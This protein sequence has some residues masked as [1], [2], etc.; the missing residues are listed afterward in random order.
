MNTPPTDTPAASP[1]P[2]TVRVHGGPAE[3]GR[4]YGS[5]ATGR[6]QRSLAQYERVYAT[7]AGLTWQEAADLAERF[8]PVI[9]A[10][11]PRLLEEI[12]GVADGAGAGFA[13]IL[14][15]NLRTEILF[16]GKARALAA[17]ATG[18]GPGLPGRGECTSFCDLRG[19]RTLA[20]Q[21]WDWIPFAH[22][23]VIVLEA[24]PG[25]GPRWVSVVEAGLLAKFGVNAAGLTVLTNAL[26]T[27]LDR[28]EPGMPYHLLLRALLDAG[29]VTEGEE[30]L[31]AAPRASSA[32]YLLVQA[33]Q[34]TDVE[35]RPGGPE[36]IGVRHVGP[37]GLLVHANHFDDLPPVGARDHGPRVMPD[38]LFRQERALA[39]ADAT[40]EPSVAGW[41]RILADH[42]GHPDSLCCHPNPRDAELGRGSTVASVI[43]EPE[44]AVLHLALGRPCSTP[45]RVVDCR[46][47]FAGAADRV[48]VP[49]VAA[50]TPAQADIGTTC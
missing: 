28:G 33:G 46:D 26:V 16:S 47:F 38:T 9:H 29:S 23:T 20:G 21:N 43:V 22:D 44:D 3:R 1:L 6:V 12:Q 37:G 49:G 5:Q 17:G 41:H 14:A 34:G 24:A 10:F 32:N 18:P 25:T 11:D 7:F 27:S 31:R 4:Q 8:V 30:L 36:A 40:P 39:L 42:A 19:P 2:P 35:A 45:R 48:L 15:L 50:A 13:D